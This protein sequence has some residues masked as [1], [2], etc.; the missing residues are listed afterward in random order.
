[1]ADPSLP[2]ILLID[3]SNAD[4]KLIGKWLRDSG[5]QHELVHVPDGESGLAEMRERGGNG[6]RPFDLVL[7]DLNL[8]RMSGLEVLAELRAD[9]ALQQT[10]I[11]VLTGSPF[12]LEIEQVRRHA[13][14]CAG[15]PEDADGFDRLV[16]QVRR[17]LHPLAAPGTERNVSERGP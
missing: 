2:S 3:D 10:R 12:P 6:Q 9:A 4:A 15:K 8:P 14:L 16:Q 7:L 5:F 17:Y 1:M 13:D 11:V